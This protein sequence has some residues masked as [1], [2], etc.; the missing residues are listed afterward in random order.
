M[1]QSDFLRFALVI[2]DGQARTFKKNLEKMVKLILLDNYGRSLSSVEISKIAAEKYSL[3]FL[4]EEIFD[5]VNSSKSNSFIKTRSNKSRIEAL[6]TITP[7]TFDKLNNKDGINV[8]EGVID[9]FIQ[10]KVLTDVTMEGF[11]SVIF[12]FLYGKFNS[13]LKTVLALMNH[14]N[15]KVTTDFDNGDFTDQEIGWINE[16]LNW[17]DAEK[18]KLI[19]K[20]ISTSYEYCMMTVK[21]DN[22]SYKSIF[23]GK[24]FYLDTNVIFRLA[25]FNNQYRKEVVNAF[26]EMCFDCGITIKYTNFTQAEIDRTLEHHVDRIR[27]V[28]DR[29][30]PI[31]ADSMNLLNSNF[32]DDMYNQY[33]EW[34]RKPN[35]Q[36][37]D[38]KGF[39]RYLKKEV[40]RYCNKMKP[41]SFTSFNIVDA[42]RFNLLCEGLS[43]YKANPHESAIKCDIENYLFM[44]KINNSEQAN[45]FFDKKNY[46]ITADHSYINW[47]KNMNVGNTPTFVLPSVWYSLMLKYRGRS[48]DDYNSFCQ[49]LNLRTSNHEEHN[50]ELDA[51]KQ[52][53]LACILSLEESVSIKEDII[54]DIH[55]R[56]TQGSVEI[57]DVQEFVEQSYNNVVENMVETAVDKAQAKHESE[58]ADIIKEQSEAQNS[59]YEAGIKEGKEEA[60][61]THVKMVVKQNRRIRKASYISLLIVSVVLFLAFIISLVTNN[62]TSKIIIYLNDNSA[63]LAILTGLFSLITGI[64]KK[65]FGLLNILPIEIPVVANKLRGEYFK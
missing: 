39:I 37:G 23:R 32:N 64:L 8:V 20:L 3:T 34:A 9:R 26:I 10:T 47:A 38:Y 27:I 51:K 21:K 31:S 2:S 25:G 55:D 49:F 43:S 30:T 16:F 18:S 44:E 54:Y 7:K 28:L 52:E 35:N 12:R 36:T 58:K 24:V 41:E 53:M 4:A 17:D 57:D 48:N 46:F 63:I 15:E 5:V 14:Q 61:K 50:E 60:F 1:N 65:L 19:F 59:K 42:E 29:Q 33:A 56:I 22:S 6:F 40:A 11:K 13:D 62:S 45:S